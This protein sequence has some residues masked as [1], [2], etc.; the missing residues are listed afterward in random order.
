MLLV[1][2]FLMVLLA[3]LWT[4]DTVQT[5]EMTSAMGYATEAN[6]VARFFVRHGE[7]DFV[8]FKMFDLVF[9]S[10]IL[11]Y[12]WTNATLQAL[13]LLAMFDLVYLATV[14]HNRVVLERAGVE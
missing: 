9:L 14:V 5:V 2:L 11:Y 1:G 6:P 8:A 12:L 13:F 4:I 3:V 7:G 10:G